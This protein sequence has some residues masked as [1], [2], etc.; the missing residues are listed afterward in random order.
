MAR[1]KAY[2]Q[3]GREMTIDV[4]QPLP[5]VEELERQHFEKQLAELEQRRDAAW[6]KTRER[7]DLDEKLNKGLDD[8]RALKNR[9][10]GDHWGEFVGHA[11]VHYLRTGDVLTLPGADGVGSKAAIVEDAT[12]E[13]LIPQPI[14]LDI[15]NIARDRGTLRSLADV[16]P[17]QR[18]KLHATL[19][20]AAATGWGKLET[21][22]S[23]TD[24]AI[25]PS[26][27][28]PDPTPVYHLATLALIG[29]DELA[30]SPANA[31]ASIV[32][33]I[34]VA[35]ADAEDTAFAA[36]TGSG[37]PSGLALA[38]NVSLVPSGQKVAVAVSNTPTWAQLQTIPWLLP[39]RYRN[40]ASWLMH[41]TS[42]QKV[43]AL[44]AGSGEGLI[45]QNPGPN[46]PGLLGWP[47]YVVDGLPDPATAGTTDASIWFA[48]VR[49][50]Y[51]VVDRQ[52]TTV[53]VLRQRYAELGLIG[54]IVRHRVGGDLL[55]PAAC[56]IYTQ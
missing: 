6:V 25:T 48:D 5:T 9:E 52:R 44:T 55:R 15:T 27:V 56:A 21:G 14:E 40:R 31:Q 35:I 32:E 23:A 50:A 2:A 49:S 18:S 24:A 51:R 13:I 33:A 19:L 46:G 34:G 29:V 8:V 28:A 47:A 45:W 7:A 30:D 20:S 41:P 11:F 3:I 42:A 16:R 10:R 37:Q 26:A 1:M 17:T 53:Q 38:A 39:T 36:G 43:A 22:T 4:N 12:G 54:I